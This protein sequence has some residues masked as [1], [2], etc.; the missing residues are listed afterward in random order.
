MSRYTIQNPKGLYFT[1]GF[2]RPLSEYFCYVWKRPLDEDDPEASPSGQIIL[3]GD[4]LMGCSRT[5]FFET[6]EK[7]DFMEVVPDDHRYAVAMDIPF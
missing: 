4:Q 1:Y 6:M 2:D 3:A 7:F 5:T